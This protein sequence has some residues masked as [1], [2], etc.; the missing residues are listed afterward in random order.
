MDT[1]KEGKYGEVV[2]FIEGKFVTLKY[3]D[4]S[5]KFKGTSEGSII[6]I[7][8]NRKMIIYNFEI[9]DEKTGKIMK[10]GLEFGQKSLW[11]VVLNNKPFLIETGV[12]YAIGEIRQD[13]FVIRQPTEEELSGPHPIT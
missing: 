13:E 4:F 11:P 10:I 2:R 5:F 12:A 6:S 9:V 1:F 8:G 3:P 7:H